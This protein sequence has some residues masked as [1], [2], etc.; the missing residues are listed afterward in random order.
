[1]K[2][3]LLGIV[4]EVA[5]GVPT[6]V[7]YT[8]VAWFFGL[9]LAAFFVWIR[10]KKLPGC[11]VVDLLISV[12]RGTPMLVQVLFLFYCLPVL[13]VYL[14]GPFAAAMAFVLNS[15]AYTSEILRGG[16]A[17]ISEGQYQACQSLGIPSWLMWKDIVGPQLL[18]VC[19]PGLVS[20][21]TTLVKDTS[22]LSFIGEGDVMKRANDLGAATYSY[23]GP[24]MVA[25]CYYY[26]MC[27]VVMLLSR[28]LEARMNYH[29]KS[30]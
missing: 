19:L 6:T 12:L 28:H 1:M 20:E 22:I 24:L 11:M 30:S 23:L 14:P 7:G 25:G 17:S 8:C 16:I 18:R 21:F 3:D 26:V 29:V 9:W 27:N 15:A 4:T 10:L 2:S 13:G 5:K